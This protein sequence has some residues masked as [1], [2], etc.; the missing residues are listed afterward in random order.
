MDVY[1][2]W[3]HWNHVPIYNQ[4]FGSGWSWPG[5]RSG[6][7]KNRIW[8]RIQPSRK[9]PDQDQIRPS[10]DLILF[11]FFLFESQYN[12]F[13]LIYFRDT[14]RLSGG[15][16]WSLPRSGSDLNEK[17]GFGS[18]AYSNTRIRIRNAVSALITPKGSRK[19]SQ[20]F[21]MAGHQEGG[22]GPGH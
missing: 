20:F 22:I 3:L 12:S 10:F 6:S 18:N 19:K 7:F 4:G 15:S 16:W 1:K 11:L 14:S 21:L 8:I 5:S 2:K 17:A 9:N 13:I